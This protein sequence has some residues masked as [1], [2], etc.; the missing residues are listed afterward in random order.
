MAM[1]EALEVLSGKALRIYVLLVSE[2]RPLGIREIRRRLGL[3]SPPLV[4]YHL[5]KLGKAVLVAR[6][7]HGRYSARRLVK[8]GVLKGFLMLGGRLVPKYLFYSVFFLALMVFCALAF[9]N[10]GEPGLLFLALASLAIAALSWA[11]EAY[12]LWQSLPIGQEGS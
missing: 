1:E 9:W 12:R 5:K 8:V 6:D 10:T 2:G 3:S 7:A 4:H 11:L